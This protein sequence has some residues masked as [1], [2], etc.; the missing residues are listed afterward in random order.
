MHY[1]NKDL[2]EPNKIVFYKLANWYSPTFKKRFVDSYFDLNN[3]NILHYAENI[4][5]KLGWSNYN[6]Y[7]TDM[8]KMLQK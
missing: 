3:K 5:Y 8:L 7:E 4:L 2:R 6:H 1:D